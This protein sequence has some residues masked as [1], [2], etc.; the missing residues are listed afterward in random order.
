[1][2]KSSSPPG[3]TLV[4]VIVALFIFSVGA[5]ALAAT[6]AVIAREMTTNSLRERAALAASNR[7][8]ILRTQCV[9]TSGEDTWRGVTT[10]WSAAPASA[11]ALSVEG[12]TTRSSS[13]GGGKTDTYRVTIGCGR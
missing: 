4:E 9:A 3:Y 11:G 6:S 1:M 2:S 12:I 10:A 8:E 5:L 7:I 13:S